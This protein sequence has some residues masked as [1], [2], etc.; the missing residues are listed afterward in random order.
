[1]AHDHYV[2]KTYLK[3]FGDPAAGGMLRAYR[4]SDRAEFPCWPA[5]V[6]REWE[7]DLNRSWLQEPTL[8]GQYRKMFEP[9]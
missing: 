3:H 4:K 1:M 2:A 6:C 9:R 5:D 8:L 7:G